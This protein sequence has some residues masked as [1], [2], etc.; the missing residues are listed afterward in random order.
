[1]ISCAKIS[2]SLALAACVNSTAG[3]EPMIILINFD[4]WKN[5][6][7]K[8]I[9]GNVLS[10]LTL[11]TGAYGYRYESNKNSFEK[12]C[13]LA[14]GTYQNSFDHKVVCRVFSRTQEIKDELI[15][16]SRTKVVAIVKNLDVNNV[17]T[18]YELMGADNGLEMSELTSPST[19]ADG[20]IYSFTLASGD[21]AKET[22]LPLTVN[23]GEEATT[24]AL[25]DALVQKVQQESI[26]V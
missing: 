17:E 22:S 19:D 24:D 8:E 13:T 15:K 26:Q 4:D 5:A 6:E 7:T 3:I 16:L 14:K 10:G 1:M 21:N 11:K 12:D 25:V 23:A 9:D 20:V 2:K 18:K